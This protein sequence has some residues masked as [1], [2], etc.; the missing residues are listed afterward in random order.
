MAKS[1]ENGSTIL[2]GL[3]GYEVGEVIEEAKGIVVEVGTD[4]KKPACP[5]CDSANSYRHGRAKKRRVLHAWS[6]GEKIYVE[7]ARDRCRCCD[8]GYSFAEVAELV[9]PH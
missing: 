9:R 5:H 8:C 2:L 4:L 3:A 6:Q 1:Q 7:I